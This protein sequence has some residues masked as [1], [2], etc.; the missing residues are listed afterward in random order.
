M[1]THALFVITGAEVAAL[2]AA[3]C[4]EYLDGPVLRSASLDTPVPFARELEQDFLPPQR[5]EA[6]LLELLSY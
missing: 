3:R 2:I 6:Q 5:F 4:F 1:S